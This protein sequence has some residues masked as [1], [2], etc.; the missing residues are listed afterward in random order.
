MTYDMATDGFLA[1][2]MLFQDLELIQ[3]AKQALKTAHAWI[4]SKHATQPIRA[5]PL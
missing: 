5:W 4:F 2:A 3:N 1:R